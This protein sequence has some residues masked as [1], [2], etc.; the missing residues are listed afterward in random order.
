MFILAKFILTY[1]NSDA[2]S[3]PNLKTPFEDPFEFL[4]LNLEP[5]PDQTEFRAFIEN[6]T[7]T[8][9]VLV[10]IFP[11]SAWSLPY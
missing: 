6:F 2:G 4:I 8:Q 1:L 5:E 10:T 3:K 7:L 11:S 9:M